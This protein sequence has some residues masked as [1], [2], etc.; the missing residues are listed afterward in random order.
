MDLQGWGELAKKRKL[1]LNKR[2]IRKLINKMRD[3]GN[4]LIPLRLYFKYGIVKVELALARGKRVYD[5]RD[6]I[7]KRDTKR[8]LERK[9]KY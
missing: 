5:K 6:D 1:L 3:K 8:E 9:V 7:A 2:E 4:T